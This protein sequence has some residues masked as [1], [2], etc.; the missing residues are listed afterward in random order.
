M[1]QLAAAEAAAGTGRQQDA[2][3]FQESLRMLAIII[4]ACPEIAFFALPPVSPCPNSP[5]T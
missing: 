1:Q 3:D 2:A 5:P 4:G